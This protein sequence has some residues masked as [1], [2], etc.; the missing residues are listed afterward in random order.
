M[1][2][3]FFEEKISTK[4]CEKVC[5][6]VVSF[7]KQILCLT[8]FSE[9]DGFFAKKRPDQGFGTSPQAGNWRR[10]N[11]LD[12]SDS[13]TDYFLIFSPYASGENAKKSNPP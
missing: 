7:A 2:G 3:P 4:A 1:S 9:N 13:N 8:F 6:C 10:L 12:L 11:D 5:K